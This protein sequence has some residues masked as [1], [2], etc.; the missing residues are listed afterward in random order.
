MKR[1]LLLSFVSALVVL[2]WG[3]VS[4]VS[5]DLEAGLLAH[6]D[7]EGDGDVLMDVTGNGNDGS[8]GSAERSD[9]GYQGGRCLRFADPD[10]KASIPGA[11][12]LV[13]N[14][15]TVAIWV[16]QES[17]DPDGENRLIYKH[18]QYNFDLL[19][20]G[21]RLE[22]SAGGTWQG[23]SAADPLSVNEWHL[24]VATLDGQVSTHYIDGEAVDRRDG[25]SGPID[26]TESD[27]LLGNMPLSS[28]VGCMDN[29]RVYNRA[30]S[31]DEVSS[32]FLG[33]DGEAVS[34]DGSLVTTWATI[35]HA[36]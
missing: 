29:L 33:S 10:R 23:T 34:P 25:I 22:I 28:F 36:R 5:A 24:V 19:R 4:P 16:N 18:G 21:G 27:L 26:Q 13:T 20:G 14:A 1:Q 30:L 31:A 15:F 6:F 17:F 32:L 35:K 8:I 7:F 12:L 11:G 2:V 3:L 9:D